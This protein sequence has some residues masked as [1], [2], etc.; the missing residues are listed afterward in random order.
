ML[1][2]LIAVCHAQPSSLRD[3]DIMQGRFPAAFY[4]RVPESLYGRENIDYAEWSKEMLRLDGIE[5][6]AF[7]EELPDISPQ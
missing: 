6:K 5:G 4:F 7:T 1:G 3:L 2:L